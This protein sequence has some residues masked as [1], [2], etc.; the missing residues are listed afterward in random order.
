MIY[1]AQ[2]QRDVVILEKIDDQWK[3]LTKKELD[4]MDLR[5]DISLYAKKAL[6]FL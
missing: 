5:E 4:F 3:L 6:E 1:F 2:A